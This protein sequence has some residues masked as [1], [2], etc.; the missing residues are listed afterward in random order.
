MPAKDKKDENPIINYY[1]IYNRSFE[2]I[3]LFSDS[4]DYK[5]F[6]TYLQDYIA[7]QRNRDELKKSFSVKGRE[8]K[9]VPHL[10]KNY[11]NQVNLLAYNLMPDH[12]HL[13]IAER[14]YKSMQKFVRSLCTRYAIYFNKKQH[15]RGSLFIGPYKSVKLV[16]AQ[17]LLYLTRFLHHEAVSKNTADD[18]ESTY[19]TYQEYIGV[20]QS[21]WINSTGVL[22]L[23]ENLKNSGQL[24]GVNDY[25]GFINN[26][27]LD[28]LEQKILEGTLI[29]PKFIPLQNQE[30]E[31]S[32]KVPAEDRDNVL[33]P[34]QQSDNFKPVH[35]TPDSP[36]KIPA[37]ATVSI[38]LFAFLMMVGM[39]NINLSSAK[40]NYTITSSSTTNETTPQPSP[41][42][43]GTETSNLESLLPTSTP[44]P[45]IS[46]VEET[47]TQSAI[48]SPSPEVQGYVKVVI[49]DGSQSVNLRDA[50][51]THSDIVAAAKDGDVFQYTSYTSGWYEIELTS[52]TYAYI[53]SEYAQITKGGNSI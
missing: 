52:G 50:P 22:E 11:F 40:T 47:A 24:S 33:I 25:A 20:R 53:S 42:V 7:P 46:P 38:S 44:T 29:E 8:Y 39:R 19:S 3:D 18:L 6:L 35:Q 10:P 28:G 13:V 15:R 21:N 17:Q 43:A 26:S 1:H 36:F 32:E 45:D 27:Q 51:N 31:D 34:N 48:A 12:F 5:T 37:F 2:N 4:E 14:S 16:N 30:I 23:F 49:S 41:E 9:G